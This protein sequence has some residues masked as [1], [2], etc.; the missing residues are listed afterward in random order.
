MPR[1]QRFV[2]YYRVSTRKQG[3]SGLGLDAQRAAVAAY[4]NGGVILA[5]YREVESGRRDDRPELAKAL[6]HCRA[7]NAV[8]LVAK[9][10]RLARR[11]S[12]VSALMDSGAE[13]IACDLPDV[14][15]L[16]V[17]I[18]AA[19]AEAEQQAISER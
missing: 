3:R 15:R 18:L 6:A 11:V 5:E 16:T 14:N 13:F 12:F 4:V 1:R 8:L 2:A 7:A 19:V 10:D 17:H 9:L